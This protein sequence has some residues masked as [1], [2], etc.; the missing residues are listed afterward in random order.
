LVHALDTSPRR[1]GRGIDAA[2]VTRDLFRVYQSPEGEAAALQGLTLTVRH[3][4]LVVLLGP[5]GSGKTTLLRI[6]AG[7]ER[8]SAGHVQVAGEALNTL[9]RRRL[10]GV[11]ARRIGI[12]NQHYHRSL[13]PHLSCRDAIGRQLELLGAPPT[14]RRHRADQLLE[15]VG[16]TDA[17]LAAPGELSGG[18]QQRIAVCAAVAHHPAL[19]L[20]DEP[21]GELDTTNATA[22]YQLIRELTDQD[23]TTVLMV[24]HDPDAPLIADRVAHIRD[25]RLSQETTPAGA[26]DAIVVGRGG[27]LRIPEHALRDAGITSH[28]GLEQQPGRIILTPAETTSRPSPQPGAPASTHLPVRRSAAEAA[29]AELTD[30]AKVYDSGRRTRV[31]FDGLTHTFD[32]GALTVIAGRSGS[33]KTTLLRLLA[34]I[35]RP[36]RGQV[37]VLGQP[38]NARS[39]YDLAAFRRTHIGYVSQAPTLPTLLSAAEAVSL[40]AAIRGVPADEADE[41]ARVWLS[42]VGLAERLDHNVDRL[43]AGERQ[44]VAVARAIVTTPEILIVDE[45]TARLDRANAAAIA[46]LLGNLVDDR[47]I[48]IIAATHDRSLTQWAHNEVRL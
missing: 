37:T 14:Q 2:V 26:S 41:L 19:L 17:A 35:D 30:V 36:T 39:R 38:L 3:G 20:A 25:G 44:R 22:I 33:G 32:R 34:G 29:A 23:H 15:R 12:L 40:S 45:P 9:S 46:R 13:P 43:S 11:R 6:L 47:H 42:Q 5:S 7:L 1:R 21:A 31:V 16:L 28:A 8:A 48:T 4:E 18:E 27:W 24:S 10:A